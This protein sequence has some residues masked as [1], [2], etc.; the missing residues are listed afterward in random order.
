MRTSNKK[1]L[2]ENSNKKEIQVSTLIIEPSKAKAT[3][4]SPKLT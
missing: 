4:H 2:L 3:D 1:D